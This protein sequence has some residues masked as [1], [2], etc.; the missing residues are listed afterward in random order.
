LDDITV[1]SSDTFEKFDVY[2]TIVEPA[3][4]DF[5]QRRPEAMRYFFAQKR[6]GITG[7]DA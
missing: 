1:L 4:I 2:F 5:T 6:V 7:V 3:D